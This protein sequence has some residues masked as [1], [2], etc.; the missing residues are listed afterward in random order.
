MDRLS[1]W[2]VTVGLLL[3]AGAIMTGSVWAE[4][5]WGTPWVWE[6]KQVLS[7]V[8]LVIYG[9]YY[10]VRHVSHWSVRR[11]SWILV[12]GFISVLTTFLGSDLLAPAGLPSFLS[13]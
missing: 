12:L 11:A 13:P 9:A 4:R 3:M 8:T 2:L 7:L 6:P 5:T 10:F 1:R